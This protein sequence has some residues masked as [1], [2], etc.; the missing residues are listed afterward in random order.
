MW[1]PGGDLARHLPGHDAQTRLRLPT[2]ETR[3]GISIRST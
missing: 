2:D 3:A 1:V